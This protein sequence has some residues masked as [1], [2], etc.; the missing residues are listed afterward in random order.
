MES[1]RRREGAAFAEPVSLAETGMSLAFLRAIGAS[2][3][4][5][6]LSPILR[7][8]L[9]Q[10]GNPLLLQQLIK[11]ETA[12]REV[13]SMGLP[14]ARGAL[15]SHRD[16]AGFDFTHTPLDDALVCQLH[17]LRFLESARN[18]VLVG[19]PGTGKTHLATS[20]GIEAS[21]LVGLRLILEERCVARINRNGMEPR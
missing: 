18:V 2:G 1:E 12:Q 11:A 8:S 9:N 21:F 16:L 6:F 15:P 5:P 20:L 4:V 13:R 7:S 10:L 14:H 19:G 3:L 17:T